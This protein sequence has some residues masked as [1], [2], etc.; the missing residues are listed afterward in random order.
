MALTSLSMAAEAGIALANSAM[1]ATAMV[2]AMVIIRLFVLML[3]SA[4]F[5]VSRSRTTQII[6]ILL[7]IPMIVLEGIK[8]SSGSVLTVVLAYIVAII[9]IAY[10]VVLVLKFLFVADRITLDMICASLCVYLL[11]GVLWSIGYS[12]L[13]IHDNHAFSFPLKEN[14]VGTMQFGGERTVTS[15][16]FSFVTMSTLGYGD[17]VPRSSLARTAAAMQAIVGQLYLAV[18]VARLVG[19]HIVH[20]TKG[21]SGAG[22]EHESHGVEERLI[23]L[24]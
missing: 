24:C 8:V 13:Q 6:A 7:A 20:A 11:L 12:L 21:Q 3:L 9:L 1:T 17:I 14:E 23:C 2:A 16:Y 10:T 18:L 19:L 22:K 15:L 5:A 4:V